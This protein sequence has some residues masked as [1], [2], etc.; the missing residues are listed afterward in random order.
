MD[1]TS[2]AE[3]SNGG[4]KDKLSGKKKFSKKEKEAAVYGG[5]GT[6]NL[7]ALGVVGY[8]G[9]RKYKGG[10][11]GW[12]ILGIAAGV[13]AGISAIEWAS[14]RYVPLFTFPEN[15]VCSSRVTFTS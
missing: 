10:E 3:D 7:L 5:V 15:S 13:W 9:W 1:E 14:I 6:L 8:W 4:L 2:S 11:N 12:K